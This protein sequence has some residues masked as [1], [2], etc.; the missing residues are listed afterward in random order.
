MIFC[1]A[2]EWQ[3]VYSM[4]AK[5]DDVVRRVETAV[6]GNNVIMLAHINCSTPLTP[7]HVPRALVLSA[8]RLSLAAALRWL[9]EHGLVA[10]A[11]LSSEW[12]TILSSSADTVRWACSLGSRP[13]EWSQQM[14]GPMFVHGGDLRPPSLSAELLDWAAG[15]PRFVALV[16]RNNFYLISWYLLNR[17][18]RALRRSVH[19]FDAVRAAARHFD[20]DPS[21]VRFA[22]YK[23]NSIQCLTFLLDS[24]IIS[25][26]ACL[27]GQDAL[28][29]IVR[30][31]KKMLSAFVRKFAL[32]RSDLAAV[33]M[34]AVF[35]A[36]L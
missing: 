1:P 14:I 27:T 36:D 10:A 29:H 11:D 32:T 31:K 23:K 13:A 16:Q 33:G 25:R 28:L 20:I 30:G 19:D 2:F 9:S 7:A 22:A 34:S 24:G 12:R 5:F 8:I 21:L 17:Q 18:R 6:H 15:D 3:S 26:A 35:S 4:A